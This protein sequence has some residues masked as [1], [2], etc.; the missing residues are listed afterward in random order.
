MIWRAYGRSVPSVSVPILQWTSA[1]HTSCQGVT[2]PYGKAKCS[3]STES[4]WQKLQSSLTEGTFHRHCAPPRK[5]IALQANRQY[6]SSLNVHQTVFV[7]LWGE[8]LIS[9]PRYRTL[10]WVWSGGPKATSWISVLRGVGPHWMLCY[11]RLYLPWVLHVDAGL[12]CIWDFPG[13]FSYTCLWSLEC[14][15]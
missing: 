11:S 2:P 12:C 5:L 8:R 13:I 7:T 3:M 15:K 6:F 4:V 9:R 14:D 1:Q 10:Y